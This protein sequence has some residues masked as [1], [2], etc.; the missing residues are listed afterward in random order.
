MNIDLNGNLWIS[1]TTNPIVDGTVGLLELDPNGHALAYYPYPA[2]VGGVSTSGW[3]A[4]DIAVLGAPSTRLCSPP[5]PTPTSSACTVCG[6][7]DG[8]YGFNQFN[9]N[10]Q[11]GVGFNYGAGAWKGGSG[12][13]PVYVPEGSNDSLSG[14]IPR[15]VRSEA[16]LTYDPS[17]LTPNQLWQSMWFQ[18]SQRAAAA[19]MVLMDYEHAGF[20]VRISVFG[21][22]HPDFGKM[23]V[24]Y[25]T[26]GGNKTAFIPWAYGAGPADDTT[27]WMPISPARHVFGISLTG[28]GLQVLPGWA[29][30]NTNFEGLSLSQ[31][32][33]D[34][35][36]YRLDDGSWLAFGNQA[37]LGAPVDGYIDD[38]RVYRC[39]TFTPPTLTPTP[40]PGAPTLSPTQGPWDGDPGH[41]RVR[42][43]PNYS[44][45]DENHIGV[46][47]RSFTGG[48][49]GL[50]VMRG[51][52]RGVCDLWQGNLRAH[53]TLHKDWD[54]RGDHGEIVASGVYY[55]VF[56]DGDGST[57]SQKI[58]IVR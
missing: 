36:P 31:T 45:G 34:Y 48:H 4:G 57:F 28:C 26:M 20:R 44:R 47:I 7:L 16:A 1:Q 19:E 14:F 13:A 50:R 46:D 43:W 17:F 56:T 21:P 5:T 3:A 49:C 6:N 30:P 35:A 10:V 9:L 32:F 24:V 18:V 54:C 41:H 42:C 51:N 40:V 52:N 58:L 37:N 11:G 25:S 39:G 38:I 15:G 53:D 2:T 23:K 33:P 27:A 8:L 55:V 22:R 12:A 29:D